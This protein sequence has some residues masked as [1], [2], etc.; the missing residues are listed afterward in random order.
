LSDNNP[1]NTPSHTD[2]PWNTP[3]PTDELERVPACPVCGSD[4]RKILHKDLIDNVFY[5]APGK[6]TSWRCSECRC[7]YLDPRPSQASI[8][9]A[10]GT[11]YTHQEAAS[12][13]SYAELSLLRKL[14]RRLVNGYTNWRYSTLELPATRLGR[15]AFL[16]AWPLKIRLDREYRH[17]P[18][19]PAGGGTLLD[20][21]CGNGY[22]LHIARTCGWH[23][24]GVDPDPKAV[25]NGLGQGLDVIQGG[26]EYF[27]G[28]DD[29][30]D[31]ITLNHVIEHVHEPVAVLNACHRLL[32]PGGQLWLETPNINSLGHRHYMKD[33]RGL[34]TPRH[35][36][37]FNQSSLTKALTEA[38]FSGIKIQSR[39][40]PLLQISR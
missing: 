1:N 17:L 27:D 16:T 32:K 20:V 4:E 21:G 7:A 28:K 31:V 8:H 30:F 40:S 38:G 23:V 11:Y 15:F 5:C 19:L 24:V 12:K 39:P 37:M 26:I 35:L 3:W 22:F 2:T 18:R 25:A 29:F 10:Y 6:W 34:E 33:W 13:S 14:R 36:V 9:M